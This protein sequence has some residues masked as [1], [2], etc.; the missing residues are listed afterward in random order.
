MSKDNDNTGRGLSDASERESFAD[1][2]GTL[3]SLEFPR[4]AALLTH[5]KDGVLQLE[6]A[7]FL[8]M[9]F[10]TRATRK[11]VKRTGR[12]RYEGYDEV[13]LIRDISASGVR[14]LIAPEPPLELARVSSMRLLLK[15]EG[16]VKELPVAVVRV[17]NVGVQGVDL[18]CRFLNPE[19]ENAAIAERLRSLFFAK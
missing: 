17:V 3:N 7:R 13:V 12:L 1:R 8:Q 15:L 10:R 9:R 5:Q 11:A 4:L 16:D 19:L 14:M 2:H 6:V 18:A